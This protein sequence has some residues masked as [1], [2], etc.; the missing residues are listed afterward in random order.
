LPIRFVVRN[1]L[2][3]DENNQFLEIFDAR[4]VKIIDKNGLEIKNNKTI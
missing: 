3:Y 2:K 4:L 1:Y